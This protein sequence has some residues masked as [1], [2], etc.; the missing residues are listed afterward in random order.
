MQWASTVSAT[1][2][3][4]PPPSVMTVGT[5]FFD[6]LIE[7]QPVALDEAVERER[8]AAQAITFIRVYARLI[9]DYVRA[10]P[11]DGAGQRAR[12]GVEILFIGR[13]VIEPYVD[14]ALLFYE[15]VILLTVK[16]QREDLRVIGED[17]SRPVALMN[18]A[19]DDRGAAYQPF[20]SKQPDGDGYVV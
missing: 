19:V 20:G 4:Y 17:V 11:L 10:K 3:E 15:R 9:K 12:Q 7:D 16:R 1:S 2:L 13:S 14:G 18:V 6:T 5:E 8:E